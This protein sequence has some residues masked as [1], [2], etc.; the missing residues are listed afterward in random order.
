MA[1]SGVFTL[2]WDD[3][4]SCVHTV[5]GWYDQVFSHCAGMT[6]SVVFILCWDSTVRCVHTVLG[7]H[8]QVCSHCAGMAC[9]AEFTPCCDDLHRQSEYMWR[10]GIKAAEAVQ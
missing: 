7:W 5:L 9:S 6:C 2:C 4:L 3:V 1:R 8:D 10:T